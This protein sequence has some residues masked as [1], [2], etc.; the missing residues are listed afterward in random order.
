MNKA[1]VKG[2]DFQ[3]WHFTVSHGHL[4]IRSPMD[5]QHSTNIDIWFR[6]VLYVSAPRFLQQ[7]DLEEPSQEEV[8]RLKS[9]VARPIE[10]YIVT[11]VSSGS[12]RHYVV[13]RDMS[14]EENE[15][16]ITRLPYEAPF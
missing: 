1:L 13:S 2:R 9:V 11:V 16:N 8:E 3:L 12:Q 6:N 15:L 5:D 7:I 14:I 4:L 10:R